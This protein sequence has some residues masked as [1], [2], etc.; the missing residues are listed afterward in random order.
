MMPLL[1]FTHTCLQSWDLSC[2]G[3]SSELLWK[4]LQEEKL[5][6]VGEKQSIL[7]TNNDCIYVNSSDVMMSF[8]RV[9]I[10]WFVE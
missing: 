4:I 1:H 9:F 7:G 8:T 6:P 2:Y 5:M 10:V 3:T